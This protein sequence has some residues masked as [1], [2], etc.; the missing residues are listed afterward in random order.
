MKLKSTGQ[1]VED[2][3]FVGVGHAPWPTDYRR[4]LIANDC[5]N[6]NR[7]VTQIVH[8]SKLSEK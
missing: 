8:I 1:V 6:G 3:P 5:K 7:A 2:L 4:V